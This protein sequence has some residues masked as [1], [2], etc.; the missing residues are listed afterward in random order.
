MGRRE[1]GARA[2]T[3]RVVESGEARDYPENRYEPCHLRERLSAN[4]VLIMRGARAFPSSSFRASKHGTSTRA[5]IRES[6]ERAPPAAPSL[7]PLCASGGRLAL[8]RG[9]VGGEIPPK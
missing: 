2:R 9:F 8:V 5:Q 1:L 4:H 7:S 3:M 6:G